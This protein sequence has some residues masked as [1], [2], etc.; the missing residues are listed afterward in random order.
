[1]KLI[2]FLPPI[3]HNAAK[4]F[5]AQRKHRLYPDYASA[6]TDCTQDA[7]EDELLCQMIADKTKI[8][9]AQLPSSSIHLTQTNCFAI[10]AL[11]HCIVQ[12]AVSTLKVLDFGGACG[13][14]Y[15]ELKKLLPT[16]LKLEWLV[17]ET[18]AMVKAAKKNNL[19]NDELSFYKDLNSLPHS[20]I[21]F[22]FSSGTLQSVP[23]PF[24]FLDNLIKIGSPYIFV[25]RMMFTSNQEQYVTVQTSK[26]SENGPGGLPD[27]Y[28]DK[29]VRYPHT[30][31]PLSKFKEV[32]RQ[33]GYGLV[34]S[35]KE[36]SGKFELLSLPIIGLGMLFIKK[37]A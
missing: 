12:N 5:M 19:G 15:F 16:S 21:D 3:V 23:S 20:D 26:L 9:F 10:A 31:I 13:A 36:D 34:W 18:P 11:Q 17:V 8:H 1:M 4:S 30:T 27:G 33:A 2:E 7:Y 29:L 6:L 24:L 22:I 35:F 25:N 28:M 37:D 14:H 32:M